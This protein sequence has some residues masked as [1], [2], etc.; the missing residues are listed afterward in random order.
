MKFNIFFTRRKNIENWWS[1]NQNKFLSN[2]YC[3]S[4][5]F[6]SKAFNRNI[7]G[8]T[9]GLFIYLEYTLCAP[10][11][12]DVFICTHHW[13]TSQYLI[14]SC[15]YVC[16]EVHIWDATLRI[17][18]NINAPYLINKDPPSHHWYFYWMPLIKSK[19]NMNMN[20]CWSVLAN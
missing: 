14:I 6:L 18:E 2:S 17:H 3:N 12:D 11:I 16:I 9:E 4:F 20:L 5:Y 15:S 19:K 13:I 7:N 1:T 10:L 8:G